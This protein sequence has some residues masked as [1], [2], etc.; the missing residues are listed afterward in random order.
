MVRAARDYTAGGG[1]MCY[2]CGMRWDM[3]L[4]PE[5]GLYIDAITA[6]SQT[7]ESK[8]NMLAAMD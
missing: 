6:L 1:M 8:L 2:C 7:S 4:K 5:A 3:R